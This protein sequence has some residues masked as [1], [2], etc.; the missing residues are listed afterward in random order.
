LRATSATV[1]RTPGIGKF[2]FALQRCSE[3][4]PAFATRQQS[5]HIDSQFTTGT[6]RKAMRYPAVIVDTVRG[7]VY[8]KVAVTRCCIN[9]GT[10][11][12]MEHV[13]S[14]LEAQFNVRRDDYRQDKVCLMERT[15]SSETYRTARILEEADTSVNLEI[16]QDMRIA[17]IEHEIGDFPRHGNALLRKTISFNWRCP[18]YIPESQPYSAQARELCSLHDN[19]FD[20]FDDAD[21][22]ASIPLHETAR[23]L[24]RSA[25]A[26]AAIRGIFTGAMLGAANFVPVSPSN[27]APCRI[28]SQTSSSSV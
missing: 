13:R 11:K 25:A 16:G 28:P 18:A 3:A 12:A 17:T 9:A 6:R 2:A 24:K 27:S 19:E 22:A 23:G 4:M 8:G 20:I 15:G 26:A 10:I 1:E 14:R 7:M 5:S 21:D